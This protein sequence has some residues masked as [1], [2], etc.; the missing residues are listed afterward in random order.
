MRGCH[1]PAGV[2]A[3]GRRETRIEV[4]LSERNPEPHRHNRPRAL[5]LSGLVT[6][7]ALRS[8][9][10]LVPSRSDWASPARLEAQR[11]KTKSSQPNERCVDPLYLFACALSW[12]KQSNT[13]AGWELVR[14]VR[15]SGQAEQ[16]AAALLVQEESLPVRS[17]EPATGHPGQ[18]SPQNT[19]GLP[20]SARRCL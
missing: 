2:R 9:T 18:A 19:V 17:R 11:A 15:S 13:T 12:R 16:I 14:Y 4:L 5:P 3:V 20:A 7:V 1:D 8:T 6:P 10:R